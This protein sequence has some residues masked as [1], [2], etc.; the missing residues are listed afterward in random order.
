MNPLDAG[1]FS[2]NVYDTLDQK[3]VAISALEPRFLKNLAARLAELEGDLWLELPDVAQDRGFAMLSK[4][5]ASRTR[6]DWEQLL[7]A[8]TAAS[9]RS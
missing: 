2:Y 8:Q 9:R 5:F 1:A 6:D 4:L 3:Y 7:Q